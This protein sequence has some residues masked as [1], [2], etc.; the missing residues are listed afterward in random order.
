MLNE[1]HD[2]ACQ[3]VCCPAFS[4]KHASPE[5]LCST[6]LPS[7]SGSIIHQFM[8]NRPPLQGPWCTLFVCMHSFVTVLLRGFDQLVLSLLVT[9][10][11]A[12]LYIFCMYALFF[13]RIIAGV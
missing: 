9:T 2:L 10:A 12:V 13:H 6:L 5:F 3:N 7:I 11:E 8:L 4:Q 1:M